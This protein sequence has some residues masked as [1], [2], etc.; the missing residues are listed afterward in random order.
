[1]HA[2]LHAIYEA[3]TAALAQAERALD[4]VDDEAAYTIDEVV[5][6]RTQ[7]EELV[8]RLR[9]LEAGLQ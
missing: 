8:T 9:A 6:L 2:R 4:E 3:M 1:M 5:A 7:A